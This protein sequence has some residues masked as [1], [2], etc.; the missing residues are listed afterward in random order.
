MMMTPAAKFW[1]TPESAVPMATPIA[2][3]MPAIESVSM[4]SESIKTMTRKILR[5]APMTESSHFCSVGSMDLRARSAL[6]MMHMINF[7]N[8]H[9]TRRSR[10]AM[11]SLITV[12]SRSI[13][14]DGTW[15]MWHRKC[16]TT[17]VH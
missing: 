11:H 5:V 9:P 7:T 14:D 10:R 1:T 13:S 4:P 12:T 8:I 16:D 3:I 6:R 15:E 2:A 17:N